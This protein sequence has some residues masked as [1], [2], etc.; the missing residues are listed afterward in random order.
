M[1]NNVVLVSA[2]HGIALY[3]SEDSLIDHNTVANPS[4]NGF[5]TWITVAD[6]KGAMPSKNVTVSN[7]AAKSFPLSSKT[8][9]L[10]ATNN[11]VVPDP[12]AAYTT[13]DIATMTFDLTPKSGSVLDGKSAGAAAIKTP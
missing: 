5:Q 7:N 12:V 6:T 2:Y 3:G 8:V 13:F 1:T 9:N 11:I 10:V 4:T